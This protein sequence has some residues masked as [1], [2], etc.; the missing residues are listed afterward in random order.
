M[1]DNLTMLLYEKDALIK[2]LKQQLAQANVWI[3]DLQEQNDR[4]SSQ[5]FMYQMQHNATAVSNDS[6]VKTEGV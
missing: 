2:R 6:N 5:L 4:L 3:S 1:V